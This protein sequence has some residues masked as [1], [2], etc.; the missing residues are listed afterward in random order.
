MAI[1]GN[2]FV[3]DERRAWMR[4]GDHTVVFDREPEFERFLADHEGTVLHILRIWVANVEP[5][6]LTV[7]HYVGSIRRREDGAWMSYGELLRLFRRASAVARHLGESTTAFR[8]RL[9]HL[10]REYFDEPPEQR[11]VSDS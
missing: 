11:N 6:S 8:S 3:T 2:I 1:A 4:M 10:L 9:S 7:R 5:D